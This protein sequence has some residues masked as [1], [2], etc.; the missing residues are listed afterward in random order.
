L[1]IGCVNT[2]KAAVYPIKA[3]VHRLKLKSFY[4]IDTIDQTLNTNHKAMRRFTI[5]LSSIVLITLLASCSTDSDS[6]GDI[7]RN[8]EGLLVWGFS[9]AQDGSGMLFEVNGMT[10]GA[11][12]ER[13]D[14]ESYFSGD[15]NSAEVTADFVITGEKT[16]RGW[17][18]EYPAIEF[19]EIRVRW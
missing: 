4:R 18:A 2:G 14:Y 7:I 11:P 15:E 19:L 17:G 8:Q 5:I 16:V 12:G 6:D 3:A 9:P 10:Y 13:S 1:S